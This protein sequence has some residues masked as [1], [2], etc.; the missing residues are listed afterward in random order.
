MSIKDKI[1]VIGIAQTKFGENFDMSYEDMAV[2]A[3]F[4]AMEDAGVGP[5]DIQAVWLST[6]DPSITGGMGRAGSTIVDVL[7]LRDR[8]VSRVTN[9]CSSGTDAFRN[10]CFAVAS[11]EYDVVLVLGCEK[12]RDVGSRESLVKGAAEG[13]HPVWGKGM[14]APGMFAMRATRYFHKYGIGRETLAKVAVKNH[15]HGSLNPYAH[16][17]KEITVDKVLKAPLI[18]YPLGLFDCTPTTDGAA[19]AVITRAENAK[20]FT[21]E[22]VLVKGLGL[23]VGVG[24]RVFFDP[25]DPVLNF[26]STKEAAKQAYEMAEIKDPRKEIDLAE[27]HDCFTITEILNYEDLGFAEEG[28]GWKLIEEGKT[29]KDGE[30][31]VNPSGGLKSLGHPIGATGVR[32]IVEVANHLL[33]RAGDRQV[34]DAKIGL[35]HNLGGP[36]S[37]ATVVILGQP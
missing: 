21:D 17:R 18:A 25:N 4:G 29:Y 7:S 24:D 2:E 22:Y 6:F 9:Y 30:I 3:A 10:A 36:G 15:Y 31:P 11:G 5:D 37:V 13:G 12:M 1:A 8:P 26:Q 19:A 20:S 14:T 23:S 33:G 27:V 16:F 32:M 28:E 35:A 34:K